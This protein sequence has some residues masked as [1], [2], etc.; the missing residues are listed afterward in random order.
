MATF[1]M[2]FQATEQVI[3]RRGQNWRIRWQIKTMETQVGQFPVGC[4]CPVGW[5]FVVQEQD[6][7][8]EL[9]A[10]GVYPSIFPSVAPAEMSNTPR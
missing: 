7:I 1:Q 8:V 6:P 5:D 4:T 2:L 9:P 3:F 10:A